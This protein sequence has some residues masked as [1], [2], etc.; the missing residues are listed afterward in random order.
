MSYSKTELIISY[1]FFLIILYSLPI[2]LLSYCSSTSAVGVQS[3][4]VSMLDIYSS[5]IE[6]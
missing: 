6:S 2:Q 1:S 5:T 4:Y 3:L